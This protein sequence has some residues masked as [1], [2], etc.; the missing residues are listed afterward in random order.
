M[1]RIGVAEVRGPESVQAGRQ[2]AAETSARYRQAAAGDPARR[3]RTLPRRPLRAFLPEAVLGVERAATLPAAAREQWGGGGGGA[4]KGCIELQG[5][6]CKGALHGQACVAAASSGST[7]RQQKVQ[8]LQRACLPAIAPS[9]ATSPMS[10]A[11]VD[12][13]AAAPTPIATVP[14]AV[15]RV[16]HRAKK[17]TGAGQMSNRGEQHGRASV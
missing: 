15:P 14:T 10:I 4:G 17:G 1:R 9:S 6:A 8:Q 16:W 12:S 11:S 2:A 5:T 7:R 3:Q 13:M